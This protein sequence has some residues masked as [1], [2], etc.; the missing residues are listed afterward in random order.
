MVLKYNEK[1]NGSYEV[2]I[3]HFEFD[4]RDQKY[5]IDSYKRFADAFESVTGRG[6]TLK[7]A[8]E[9][10]LE[11]CTKTSKCADSIL[12]LIYQQ[13]SVDRDLRKRGLK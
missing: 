10:F 5:D 3:D 7:E 1:S 13:V 6:S 8:E 2:Y 12:N 11:K 4:D 9:D